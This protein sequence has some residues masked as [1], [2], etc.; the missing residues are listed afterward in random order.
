MN[1]NEFINL[2]QNIIKNVRLEFGYNQEE[3]ASILGISK[4]TLVQIEKERVPI[5]WSVGVAF[6][7]IFSDSEILL[8][9]FGPNLNE[10]I[11]TLSFGNYL[12]GKNKTMGGKVWWTDVENKNG[13]RLQQ[14]IISQHYR[15]LDAFDF[16]IISSFDY[17]LILKEYNK[18]INS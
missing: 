10:I 2:L 9:T 12:S 14:N 8:E 18:I 1:K 16:R 11:K 7:T 13:Y 15:I 6:C 5:G 3:M 4:K 17:D